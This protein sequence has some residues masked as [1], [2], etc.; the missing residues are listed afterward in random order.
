[1][2][3]LNRRRSKAVLKRRNF[4]KV[5]GTALATGIS[6][7]S[8]RQAFSESGGMEEHG[9]GAK[10]DAEGLIHKTMGTYPPVAW[11]DPKI[12][13]SSPP[14]LMGKQAGQ[15]H[16]LNVPPLGYEMDGNVKIFTLIAQPVKRYLTEGRTPDESIVKA[17]NRFTGG[18]HHMNL[19]KQVKLWGYNGSMPGPTIEVTQ[20]DRVR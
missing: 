17:S 7:F 13:I 6:V 15:V 18:M 14:P 3:L 4:L 9:H 8:G 10:S 1:M 5:V 19:P 16:T 20:G 12:P 2:V 11:A